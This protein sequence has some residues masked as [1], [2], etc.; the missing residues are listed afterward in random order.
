[1]TCIILPN[2]NPYFNLAAE[3]FFLKNS[4]DDFL[5]LYVNRPSVIVGRHQNLFAEINRDF[6]KKNGILYVRRLTGGGA[7]YHDYGNLNFSFIENGTPGKL[8]NQKKYTGIIVQ[9]LCDFKLN[10]LA[11]PRNEITLEGKKISGCAEHVYKSR[12]LHH[13]TLL[14]SSDLDNLNLSLSSAAGYSD[15]AVRSIRSTVTN[16]C[17]H[18]QDKSKTIS[19]FKQE[20]IEY[21]HKSEIIQAI[22]KPKISESKEIEK[23]DRCKYSTW[24]WNV[25]YSPAYKIERTLQ[26][27][28]GALQIISDIEGGMIKNISLISKDFPS[29][30]IRDLEKSIIKKKINTSELKESLSGFSEQIETEIILEN[31]L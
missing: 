16:I 10:A 5:L 15:R 26:L 21:L 11:G 31:L 29:A 17:D 25:A 18:L 12:V 9:V 22:R 19:V 4:D 14:F 1:M 23:L 24:E 2:D 27:K 20:V 28:N 6:V 30:L 7:V 8:A 3:E 13:G